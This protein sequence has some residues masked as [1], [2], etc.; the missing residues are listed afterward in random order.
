[1]LTEEDKSKKE[2]TSTGKITNMRKM[3]FLYDYG[4]DFIMWFWHF[5][6]WFGVFLVLGWGFFPKYF[7][8]VSDPNRLLNLYL[9][10]LC[11][12]LKQTRKLIPQVIL[13]KAHC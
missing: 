6:V 13:T 3:S 4:L 5:L 8:S 7:L 2:I 11:S 10:I 12:L 9:P 1:M